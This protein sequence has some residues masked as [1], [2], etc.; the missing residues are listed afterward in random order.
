MI[1]HVN[2]G[3]ENSK[4][5]DSASKGAAPEGEAKEFQRYGKHKRNLR[6]QD[7]QRHSRRIR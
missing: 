5:K 6:E 7:R 1:R 4:C 3:T 2:A